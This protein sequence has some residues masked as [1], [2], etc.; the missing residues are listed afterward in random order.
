[1]SDLVDGY[2]PYVLKQK[3][4][5][6]IFLKVVDMIAIKYEEYQKQEGESIGSIEGI[7]KNDF[8][9]MSKD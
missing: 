4:P 7:N 1:M 8:K 2:F 3:Y 5:N 9:P 6:G